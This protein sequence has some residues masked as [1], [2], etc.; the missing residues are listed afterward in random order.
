VTHTIRLY[1]FPQGLRYTSPLFVLASIFLLYKGFW[2]VTMIIIIITIFIFTAQYITI[3]D[4]GRKQFVDAFAFFGIRITKERKKYSELNLIVVTK[5]RY[6]QNI[7]TRSQ[8]RTL[9]WADYTA[10][11]IYD[12]DQTLD[13]VTREDKGD[14]VDFAKLYSA[15]LHVAVED[16][17]VS[18]IR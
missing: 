18:T 10:T 15:S 7:N 17:S 11:L 8:S 1:Y 12:N 13:L 5:S 2:F 14:V 9:R 6:E 16:R 4:T 3:I